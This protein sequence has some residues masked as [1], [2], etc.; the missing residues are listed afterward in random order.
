MTGIS[1]NKIL[2]RIPQ[3]EEQP[4]ERSAWMIL[5]NHVLPGVIQQF[6]K[7]RHCFTPEVT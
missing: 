6:N 5:D 1:G 2:K 7:I 4:G 3:H